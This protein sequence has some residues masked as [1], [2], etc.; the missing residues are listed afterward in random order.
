MEETTEELMSFSGYPKMSESTSDWQIDPKTQNLFQKT[1]WV[2]MEKIHGSNFSFV[3]NGNIIRC[4]K[5]KNYL[6]QNEP[7]FSYERIYGKIS[8]KIMKLFGVIAK[9]LTTLRWVCVFGE[10]FGGG[11]PAQGVTKVEEVQ[12]VQT[13]IYY[14]PDVEYCAFDILV[15][16]M[17]NGSPKKYFLDFSYVMSLF[18]E[19]GLFYAEPLFI[20]KYE[21]CIQFDLNFDSTIPSKLGLPPLSQNNQAEGI[22]IKPLKEILVMQK[23]GPTRAIVKKKVPQFSEDSKFHQAEKWEN[24][25]NQTYQLVELIEWEIQPLANRNRL[26]NAIS[27]IGNVQLEDKPRVRQLFDEYVQDIW[28]QIEKDFEVD[29]LTEKEKQHI[30][31]IIKKE[32]EITIKKYFRD[33]K[34]ISK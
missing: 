20:G 1:D 7:F 3:T 4:A 31:Q 8:G 30:Q 10:L 14:C 16:E 27:K 29:K 17:E 21:K 5:R 18:K 19:V 12:L 23:K 22:V 24:K 9:K 25:Q 15:E 6:L 2:V 11:Y 28:E 32:A 26:N 13:G 34:K 33:Q